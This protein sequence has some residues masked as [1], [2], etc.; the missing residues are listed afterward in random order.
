MKLRLRSVEFRIDAWRDQRGALTMPIDADP[1]VPAMLQ[2]VVGT[3]TVN[4]E[5]TQEQL[6]ALGHQVHVRCPVASM[7]AASGCEVDIRWVKAQ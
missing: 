5:A 3:A 2:S 7:M 1:P 6:D 4:T